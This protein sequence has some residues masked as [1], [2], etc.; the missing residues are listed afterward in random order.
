[1]AAA[2][3]I[4]EAAAAIRIP[5]AAAAVVIWTPVAAVV[6]VIWTQAVAGTSVVAS[7][8]MVSP[9]P[10][11]VGFLSRVHCVDVVLRRLF[12]KTILDNCY[13]ELYAC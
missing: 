8:W 7:V 13:T 2:V 11:A 10:R 6:M 4:P 1:M 3:R 12:G 5:V 9:P